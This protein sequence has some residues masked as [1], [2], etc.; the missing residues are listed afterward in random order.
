MDTSPL[1]ASNSMI[2]AFHGN[3]VSVYAPQT[4]CDEDKKV[5]FWKLMDETMQ[6]I[7]SSEIIWLGG[8]LNGH[9]VTASVPHCASTRQESD[10]GLK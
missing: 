6:K 10:F 5:S 2:L 8:D 9:G 4:G 7:P 3:V 1:L